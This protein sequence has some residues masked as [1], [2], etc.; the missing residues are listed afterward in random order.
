MPSARPGSA[1]ASSAAVGDGPST[2][3]AGL[4][5]QLPS[6]LN[7]DMFC[8]ESMDVDVG[9]PAKVDR[10]LLADDRVMRNLLAVET[11]WLPSCSDPF[12][13][14]QKELRPEMREKLSDWMFTVCE[15]ERCETGVFLLSMNYVD[16]SLCCLPIRKSQLQ[17]LGAVC[18]LIASK[19]KQTNHLTSSL[20]SYY[21][22]YSVLPDD[23][24]DWELMV[25][26]VLNWDTSSVT[27]FDFLPL[28]LCR[29]P[30]LLPSDEE[31]FDG[32]RSKFIRHAETLAAAHCISRHCSF[33]LPSTVAAASISVAARLIMADKWT[34]DWEGQLK[35]I[36]DCDIDCLVSCREQIFQ[37]I[38]KQFDII[39]PADSTTRRENVDSDKED[40]NSPQPK[41]ITPPDVT[42]IQL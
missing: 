6:N 38:P 25:L 36:I 21:T 4:I 18:L 22:D 28:I 1:A 24:R 19:V 23:I 40:K 13:D 3:T 32:I 17:L 20:L 9:R 29:L 11:K 14:F 37:T 12:K 8:L 10:V 5:D 30:F 35:N 41:R 7:V 39:I 27:A 31:S 26:T 33:F 2:V 34:E 16:R 15:E 42:D